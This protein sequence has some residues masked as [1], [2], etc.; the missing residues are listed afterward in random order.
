[1]KNSEQMANWRRRVLRACV[2]R[3]AAAS[4]AVAAA[5]DA[6]AA[7]TALGAA[8]E[9]VGTA[10]AIAETVQE[11]AH[12]RIAAVVTRCLAAVFDEPY[13]FAIMFERMRGRTEARLCLMRNGQ[14]HSAMDAC[15]GGVVDVAAFALRISCL[16]L[17]KPPRRRLVVLDEPFKFVSRDRR[18]RVRAMLEALASE[19]DV[20]FVMVT[21]IEEL[22]CG[23]V[24]EING[25]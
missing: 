15:G 8:D 7:E 25:D 13:E 18:E 1:M 23:E 4:R 3:D 16:M 17:A 12:A 11:A 2:D 19:L 6:I 24:I 5:N 20:Q 22:C 9:A 10:Q 21:H 14:E